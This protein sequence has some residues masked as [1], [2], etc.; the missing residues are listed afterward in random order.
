MR[1]GETFSLFS[2]WKM[3]LFFNVAEEINDAPRDLIPGPLLTKHLHGV[4]QLGETWNS[5]ES[6]YVSY[7]QYLGGIY[8]LVSS[9]TLLKLE[10]IVSRISERITEHLM[11]SSLS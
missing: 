8:Q 1:P 2:L 3:K 4:A 9:R 7:V 5:M 6:L 11:K 10:M